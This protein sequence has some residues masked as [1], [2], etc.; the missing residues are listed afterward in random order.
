MVEYTQTGMAKPLDSVLQGNVF[1]KPIGS[2]ALSLSE[3]ATP[4]FSVAALQT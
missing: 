4:H 2:T 3:M 1:L